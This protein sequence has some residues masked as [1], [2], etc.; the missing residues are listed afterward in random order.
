VEEDLARERVMVR[1]RWP[2]GVAAPCPVCKRPGPVYDHVCSCARTTS[3]LS[4]NRRPSWI[5]C[6]ARPGS[7]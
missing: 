7:I 5:T 3:T 1:V 6:S 2:K 4:R